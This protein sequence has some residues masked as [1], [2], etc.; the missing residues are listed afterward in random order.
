LDEAVCWD[1]LKDVI[2]VRS[3]HTLGETSLLFEKIEDE[4]IS[5]QLQKLTL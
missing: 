1:S 2:P 4:E 3:H 5:A